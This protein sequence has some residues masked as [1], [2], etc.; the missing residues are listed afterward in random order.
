[1]M[2][3][4]ASCGVTYAGAVKVPP[5]RRVVVP[6]PAAAELAQKLREIEG[7]DCRVSGLG[8]YTRHCAGADLAN[9]SVCAWRGH[10]IGDQMIYAGL[11]D[12]LKRLYP[13]CEIDYYVYPLL[14]G[15]WQGVPE[16]PFTVWS[17]PVPWA[18]WTAY[19]YHLIGEA[20]CEA[21]REPDQPCAWDGLC[22]LAGLAPKRVPAAWKRPLVPVAPADFDG[23]RAWRRDTDPGA[24][25]LVV[26]CLA[27]STPI[28]SYPPERTVHALAALA[29]AL[30]DEATIAVVGLPR[31][32]A[33]YGP[34]RTRANI[35]PATALPLRQ[36]LALALDAD[37]V[38]TPDSAL[39]HAAAGIVPWDRA[40]TRRPLVVSLWSSFSPEDRVKYYPNH[41]PI[42]APLAEC[43]PCRRHERGAP[44]EGC[45]RREQTGSVYCA[46]LAAIPPERIAVAVQACL[47]ERAGKVPASAV[48]GGSDA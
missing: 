9:K 30:G 2:A 4:T 10:G 43:S 18:D 20:L 6:T 7:A 35:V 42:W 29:D 44:P 41:R 24:G 26:W 23:A 31:D 45:P 39:G 46:G 47:D 21:D 40:R 28:R 13:T 5:G 16:L 8:Q 36:V 34:L 25:P 33:A 15:L 14:A 22:T 37:V 27:A 19:D 1:M 17:E 32:F 11:L 3:I 12:I 38:V 48:Q